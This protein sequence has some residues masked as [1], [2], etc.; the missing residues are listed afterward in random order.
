MID[1]PNTTI[2][3]IEGNI[4]SGKSTVLKQLKA[5]CPD[6]IFVDEPVSEWLDLKNDEGKSLLELFYADKRRWSYTFQNVAIFHRFKNLRNAVERL[7][8]TKDNIIVMERSLMTDYNIF[9]KMLHTDGFIDG[10]EIQIYKDWFSHLHSMLPSI[11]AHI[12]IRADPEVCLQ[13]I[14]SRSREGESVIPLSY[15]KELDLYHNQWLLDRISELTFEFWNKSEMIEIH[16][17]IA[18]VKKIHALKKRMD[19]Q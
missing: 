4:G 11:D 5:A 13:R 7:D 14:S 16:E 6:W 19:S 18:F 17:I 15:L 2:I 8:R 9:T 12:Y 3:S 10:L 1:I